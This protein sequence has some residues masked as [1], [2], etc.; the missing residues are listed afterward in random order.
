[1]PV[2]EYKGG[3]I[4]FDGR[5]GGFARYRLRPSATANET[6]VQFTRVRVIAGSGPKSTDADAARR[7]RGRETLDGNGERGTG[8]SSR[9]GQAPT[10][11]IRVAPALT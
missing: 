10:A 3:Y 1:M 7:E 6:S 8:G 11:R 2:L 4:V 5:R 9:D